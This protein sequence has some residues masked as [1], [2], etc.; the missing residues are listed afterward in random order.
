MDLDVIFYSFVA[1]EYLNVDNEKL[2]TVCNKKIN[3]DPGA[4]GNQCYIREQEAITG[5]FQELFVAIQEKVNYLYDHLQLSK[6]YK[7]Q[8]RNAWLNR[9][10]TTST[11]SAH[12]H[13]ESSLSGVYY[14]NASEGSG[15]LEFIT[16]VAAAPYTFFEGSV[17][18]VNGFNSDR[19]TVKPATGKLIIFPSWL[20]HYV[21]PNTDDA[22]RISI[23]F[24]TNFVTNK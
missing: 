3:E 5:E 15:D 19:W 20:Y 9:N 12:C 4:K 14:V 22:E 16:P 18:H 2:K 11:S 8:I 13:V 24:N 21:K 6:D 10:E 23:A 1:T 17:E 7:F